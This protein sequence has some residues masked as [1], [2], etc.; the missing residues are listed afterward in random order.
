MYKSKFVNIY[1]IFFLTF[2][3]TESLNILAVM[4]HVGKS[5]QLVFEPLFRKLALNG[6]KVT[7]ITRYPQKDP[8][9]NW[10]DVNVAPVSLNSTEIFTFNDL[11]GK[12][13]IF[14]IILK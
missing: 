12:P 3:L 1:L 6:H 14:F 13:L 7:L 8:V 11:T 9:P 10:R 2:T 4:P 5:H